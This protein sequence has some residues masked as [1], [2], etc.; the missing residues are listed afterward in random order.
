MSGDTFDVSASFLSGMPI[1][2][3]IHIHTLSCGLSSVGTFARDT[4]WSVSVDIEGCVR[5]DAG[6]I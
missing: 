6:V 1:D 2:R 3:S 5:L 4:T